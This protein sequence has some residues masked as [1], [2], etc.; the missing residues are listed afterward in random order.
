MAKSIAYQVLPSGVAVLTI[1]VPDEKL[2]VLSSPLMRELEEHLDRLAALPKGS[3][4]G[5]II[6]SGKEDFIVGANID[7]IKLIARQP[8]ETFN[9]TQKGK[10]VFQKLADLPFPTVVLLTGMTFG[11]GTELA[12]AC[13]YRLAAKSPKTKIRLPE[14]G[15][16]FV[17]GWG[18]CVRLPKLIG[19]ETA[20][21]LIIQ[22]LKPF[23]A[24]KSWLVGLVDELVE[25]S[26]LQ[27]RAEAILT[28]SRVNR[29]H[30][31]AIKRLRRY[32]LDRTMVGRWLMAYMT[33]GQ[34]YRET[35]GNYP[36]A[37]AALK[38]VLAALTQPADKACEF[39][40]LTFSRLAATDI[41][42]NLIGVHDATQGSKKT[43]HT[44]KPSIK[45]VK[46][47][48]MGAGVMGAG[49]AQAAAYSGFEVV[50][51]D[52]FPAGLEKGGKTVAD[53]FNGL[54][55]KGKLTRAEADAFIAKVKLTG[56]T[57]DLAGCDLVIEAIV[58]DMGAKKSALAN[59]E[60]VI[61][62]DFI[63]ATN[64]S[65][66]SVTVMA[67]G[68]A[69]PHRVGGLHFFNP[70]H[71]M[72]L[73]EV[74]KGANTSDETEAILKSFAAKL[75]KTAITSGDE[76]GFIVNRILAPYLYAAIL[77]MEQGVP[78]K[79]IEDAMTRFGMPM[80]PLALLDEVGLDIGTKVMHVLEAA[81]G[82]RFSSPAVLNF[83]AEK[84]LVG[85]KGGKGIYLYDASGK[86]LGLNPDLLAYLNS[87]PQPKPLTR[88]QK[89]TKFV[90]SWVGMVIPAVKPRRPAPPDPK[91][92]NYNPKTQNEIQDRLVLAMVA[93]AARVVEEGVQ[94][95]P[96]QV[97][98][99]MVLGTGF[100]A[101]RGGV[102]RYADTLGN[103]AVV[104]KLNY[105]QSVAGDNYKPCQLLLDK[106]EA[107][108]RFY[109]D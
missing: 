69:R 17:P 47:G 61:G 46:V 86:R 12:L 100:P 6:K 103:R 71:K 2:N 26:D 38:V 56:D 78:I 79:D 90:R 68:C 96:S 85:K 18:G 80:G 91:R 57:K 73:V 98:L 108:V 33:K 74:I 7:E 44:G 89:L 81:F 53:L 29:A 87:P 65:S 43:A 102:L 28:G 75:N 76:A 34:I 14:V 104:Q 36:A 54:V 77:L 39:E 42:R 22:S 105:L 5:L 40:S 1:D 59:L 9:A 50:L 20:L 94:S 101:F 99:A 19:G 10:A 35:K 25:P 64:T 63:F 13:T 88:S 49:I 21:E 66:L 8:L 16:G 48:V 23:D 107:G 3:L 15:L 27:V 97:D 82:V 72:L 67:E 51:Y 83:F 11:G 60:G 55:E 24:R 32:A 62:K 30:Q 109:N 41:S 4:R 31:S 45:V 93:E 37:P 70:V 95:D 52:K 58:E 92:Y 106:A 84:K